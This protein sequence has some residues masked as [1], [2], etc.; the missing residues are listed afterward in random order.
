MADKANINIAK[1]I[2]NSWIQYDNDRSRL[3]LQPPYYAILITLFLGDVF[4]KL[5]IT[6]PVKTPKTKANIP[7]TLMSTTRELR[8]LCL[9]V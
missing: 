9:L 8:K 5:S 7:S 4:V 1:Q 3:T 6:S 2:V